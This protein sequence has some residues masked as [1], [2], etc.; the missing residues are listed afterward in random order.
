MRSRF[1]SLS[2]A[3][4]TLVPVRAVGCVCFLRRVESSTIEP[5]SASGHRMMKRDPSSELSTSIDASCI[6]TSRLE[7]ARPRPEPSLDLARLESAW[8]NGS[9]IL[10]RTLDQITIGKVDG[11]GDTEITSW[12]WLPRSGT[13]EFLVEIEQPTISIYADGA[14][15]GAHTMTAGELSLFGSNTRFGMESDLDRR[16]RWSWFQVEDL[17]P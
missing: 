12:N 16:S 4:S 17:V 7:S 11:S 2:S 13:I 1:T 10:D 14:L 3:S 8:W 5:G 6:S 15:V 9:K